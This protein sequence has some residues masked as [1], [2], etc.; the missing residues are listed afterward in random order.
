MGIDYFAQW[1]VGTELK[2]YVLDVET[3][4]E[5]G[6]PSPWHG[7]ND[8][9][10]GGIYY[11]AKGQHYIDSNRATLRT[12]LNRLACEP[13]LLVGHN[14][15]F[16]LNWLYYDAPAHI[17]A[18]ILVWDTMVGDYVYYGQQYL[19]SS[20]DETA[21][22]WLCSS[23]KNPL[24]KSYIGKGG[25]VRDI[26]L[27]QLTQYLKDDLHLTYQVYVQQC[28]TM[29]YS[30]VM[31]TTCRALPALSEIEC[32]GMHLNEQ[33]NVMECATLC[34]VTNRC[35]ALMRSQLTQ[36]CADNV[37]FDGW[38]YAMQQIVDGDIAL[39]STRTLNTF[40]FGKPGL[41]YRYKKLIGKYKNGNDKHR[42]CDSRFEPKPLI[43]PEDLEKMLGKKLNYN[44]NLG[45][46]M[47]SDTLKSIAIEY[48]YNKTVVNLIDITQRHR[49]AA[50]LLGTY[51]EPF[52]VMYAASKDE[53]IHPTIHQVATRTGRTSSTKPNA[54]NMPKS[55]RRVFTSRYGVAG[56]LL[57]SDF[58]Q[59]E[60]CALAVLTQDPTLLGDLSH[61]RDLH[62]ETGKATF[63]WQTIS[64][65]S[66]DGRRAVKAINFGLIYGGGART[67]SRESGVPIRKV[68]QQINA[69]YQR[70]PET[71]QWQ[72]RTYSA[73]QTNAYAEP[74]RVIEGTQG[75]L[76][77]LTSISGRKYIFRD[78]LAPAWLYKKTGDKLSFSP[79]QVKNYPVQGL[80]TADIVQM[81]LG[82]VYIRLAHYMERGSYRIINTV[83][84]SVLFDCKST[85]VA[86]N[87]GTHLNDVAIH[88]KATH[89]KDWYGIQ[90]DAPL[91]LEHT[92]SKSWGGK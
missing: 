50:K 11:P 48:S 38:D 82:L 77:C 10:L 43:D 25:R 56:V 40:L 70:Y 3:D 37:M 9:V 46:S 1:R 5:D 22:R 89:I 81:F 6:D 24:L 60:V 21:A 72:M 79:T 91:K 44:S 80:A 63:G 52:Q 4:H 26:P 69:W 15:K 13:I 27:G 55:V 32:S 62:Y 33:R 14:I 67:L 20:L 85:V 39:F 86:S 17:P 71:A 28:S 74:N 29:K 45:Y 8:M 83:H 57:E 65:M 41:P 51:H 7:T 84:D 87:I 36:L 66:E 53:Q 12:H 42:V 34:A 23:K 68:K 58:S 88:M 18:N 75:Q 90:W 19:F 61:G 59:L 2:A 30:Q 92:I 78:Q 35:A 47:D 49:D 73:V 31:H 16:D 54:Q 64:D 76:S